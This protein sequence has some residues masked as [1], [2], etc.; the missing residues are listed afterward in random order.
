MYSC[1]IYLLY[2]LH[3]FIVVFFFLLD[4]QIWK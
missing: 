2:I 4:L 1:Y 3:I